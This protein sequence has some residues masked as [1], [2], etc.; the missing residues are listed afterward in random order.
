MRI[1][2]TAEILVDITKL[3]VDGI[4]YERRLGLK[5]GGVTEAVEQLRHLTGLGLKEATDLVTAAVPRDDRLIIA[6]IRICGRSRRR[7]GNSSLREGLRR[8]STP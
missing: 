3:V 2:I 1:N 4:E 8:V 6:S 5:Y 7:P